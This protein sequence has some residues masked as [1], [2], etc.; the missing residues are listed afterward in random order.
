MTTATELCDAALAA[1]RETGVAHDEHWQIAMDCL[2]RLKNKI[3][4][5]NADRQKWR[6]VAEHQEVEYGKLY[7]K[8][9]QA[10]RLT[11]F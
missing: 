10:E 11:V 3:D 1:L 8:L 5:L 4:I 9:Q 2:E 6:N 7:A